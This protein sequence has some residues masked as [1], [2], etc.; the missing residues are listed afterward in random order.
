MCP[1]VESGCRPEGEKTEKEERT[2]RPVFNLIR[3]LTVLPL[4]AQSSVHACIHR[5]CLALSGDPQSK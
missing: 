1:F 3:P 2:A 5:A 4:K